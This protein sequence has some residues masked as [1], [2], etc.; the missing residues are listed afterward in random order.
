MCKKTK[1]NGLLFRKW[2]GVFSCVL[3]LSSCS[4][5]ISWQ[6][7]DLSSMAESNQNNLLPESNARSVEFLSLDPD[8]LGYEACLENGLYHV[9]IENGIA[10]IKYWDR[11][12][13]QDIY[14]CPNPNCEHQDAN[15]TA[16]LTNTKTAPQ[17]AATNQHIFLFYEGFYNPSGAQANPI[18]EIADRNGDNRRVLCEL[19]ANQ[20]VSQGIAGNDNVLYFI[21]SNLTQDNSGN[22]VSTDA[23]VRLDVQT[24]ELS[25]CQTLEDT[26]AFLMAANEYDLIYKT[27]DFNTGH[28]IF[29]RY[30]IKEN[31]TQEL[32]QYSQN[33]CVI[34]MAEN[35]HFNFS[36]QGEQVNL[37]AENWS[38]DSSFQLENCFPCVTGA[39][40]IQYNGLYRN[41][42]FV[43]SA[44]HFTESGN[45]VVKQY[46][47][48]LFARTI[49]EIR[50]EDPVRHRPIEIIGAVGPDENELVLKQNVYSGTTETSWTGTVLCTMQIEDFIS[51]NGT[52]T[53]IT[54]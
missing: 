39:P 20:E 24:G 33:E 21:L 6:Q 22:I 28:H 31:K 15:C 52:P 46:A 40:G 51:G 2:L 42:L 5:G 14:L 9:V 35:W 11:S 41:V 17:I 12:E 50:Y 4:S 10:K 30:N 34:F 36:F 7:N 49:T 32:T 23:L 8:F 29:F 26:S 54:Q 1:V 45:L 43:S 3:L 37:H 13:N 48:D 38:D 18:I 16:F 47:I 25:E 27:I 44:D 19:S 53:E